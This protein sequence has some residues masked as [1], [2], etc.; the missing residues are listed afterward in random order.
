M[1]K[2]EGLTREEIE[3]RNIYRRWKEKQIKFRENELNFIDITIKIVGKSRIWV[4]RF[5]SLR[6]L[7]WEGFCELYSNFKDKSRVD[8]ED[9]SYP[10]ISISPRRFDFKTTMNSLTIKVFPGKS[11]NNRRL[12]V[13]YPDY[14]NDALKLA[15]AY[16]EA[17][18][19]EFTVKKQYEE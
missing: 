6:S 15:K 10:S 16:E 4:D 3:E 11:F 17:G 13:Y 8:V 18:F 19:G 12:Q 5:S 1:V 7:S 14:L 2:L 9:Y